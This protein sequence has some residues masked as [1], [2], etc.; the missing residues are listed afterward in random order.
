MDKSP[1]SGGGKNRT[2][3]S[4]GFDTE[5]PDWIVPFLCD[6]GYEVEVVVNTLVKRCNLDQHNA[7][8]LVEAHHLQ[9]GSP[10]A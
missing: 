2:S 7:R 10:H 3:T 9:G 8:R 4:A 6:L 5:N 1:V